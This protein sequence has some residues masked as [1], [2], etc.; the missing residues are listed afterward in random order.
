M[1][2]ERTPEEVVL[3]EEKK[4]IKDEKKSLKRDQKMQ[5]KEAKK[6]AKEIARRETELDDAEEGGGLATFLATI[7]IVAVW[8]AVIVII[9]KLDIGGFGSNVLTP[10]LKDVPVVN[11]ILPG[12]S[13]LETETGGSYDGYTS[14]KDAVDQIHLLEA[15]LENAKLST[16]SQ[17]EE[18]TNLQA[19][20]KRLQEFEQKQ[21]EFQR[22]KTEF[23]EEVVYAEKGPGAEEYKKYYE[24]MDPA[25]AEYIYRQVIVQLEED[26][27]ILE[28]ASAYSQM[29]PKQAAGIFEEMDS[30]L[31]L[32]ARILNAMSADQRGAILGVMDAEIAAKLTKIMDPAS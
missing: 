5:R 1:A 19:E 9:I 4:R 23:F 32:V 11:K 15:E 8:L 26:A 10:V 7:L 13:I 29:K 2:R 24:A 14:L 6:R 31:E 17:K 27:K 18:I 22:I 30:D 12:Y 3:A 21:V 28:Y 25:T 20:V 16:S